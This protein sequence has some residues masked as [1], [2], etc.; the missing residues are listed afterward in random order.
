[1]VSSAEGLLFL[2]LASFRV[3]STTNMILFTIVTIMHIFQ[4]SCVW[5]DVAEFGV[6]NKEGEI[7]DERTRD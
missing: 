1:M 5:P 2:T 3:F 7:L 4:R 6:P